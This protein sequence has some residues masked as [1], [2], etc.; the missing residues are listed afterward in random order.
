MYMGLTLDQTA[1]PILRAGGGAALTGAA[2]LLGAET[3][4]LAF[5]A[6]DD[7]MEIRDTVTPANNYVGSTITKFGSVRASAALNIGSTGL[8]EW[9]PENYALRS[10]EFDNAA[11]W[12]SAFTVAANQTTAPDGTTTMDKFTVPVTTGPVSIFNTMNSLPTG[13][14]TFSIYLRPLVTARYITL[15]STDT[16][17][18]GAATI[19]LQTG[20]I[21]QTSGTTYTSSTA[22]PAT[23]GGYRLSVTVSAVGAGNH[24]LFLSYSHTAT[25]TPDA[26][27][28]NASAVGTGTE[29]FYAWGAS[30]NRGASAGAYLSTTTSIA[31]GL[32]RDYDARVAGPKYPIE[33]A[34][35]NRLIRSQELGFGGVWTPFS[36]TITNDDAVAPDGTTTAEKMLIGGAN[37]THQMYQQ[38][39]TTANTD[40]ANS[41]FAK[42]TSGQ[43]RYC[44]LIF[45]GSGGTQWASATFD[46]QTQT[47]SQTNAG[48]AG[49]HVASG[50]IPLANGWM[51][52]WMVGKHTDTTLYWKFTL[53]SSGTPTQGASGDETFSGP[54]TAYLHIWG[55]DCQ[56]GKY[57][58]SHI[59]T[60]GATVTRAAD[61]PA[62]LTS[63]FNYQAATETI[64][65]KSV[66]PHLL[67]NPG[68]DYRPMISIVGTGGAGIFANVASVYAE[69]G[70]TAAWTIGSQVVVLVDGKYAMGIAANNANLAINGVI[71]TLD[72]SVTVPSA[73][74]KI[75]IGYDDFVRSWGAW[76]NDG[77][78]LPRRMSDAELVTRTT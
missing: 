7:S 33:E 26:Q 27:G 72:T 60:A 69:I 15:A 22:T 65:V 46:L 16:T 47:V 50:V 25:F 24:Y 45:G 23:G 44:S 34:R 78:Q 41:I 71:Q 9:G 61:I 77:M 4:G 11:T 55:A 12:N 36:V 39:V 32:R 13:P 35:T 19:D 66:T 2:T 64:Y 31:Y 37:S 57:V 70:A 17:N 6:S 67:G 14:W 74:T 28:R 54:G 29:T 58:G 68:S 3:N 62:V 52:L 8:V 76:I 42:Y 63:A 10:Q 5:S 48:A 21:T 53:N 1:V 56:Y 30:I 38:T 18:H 51:R 73:V 59:P 49:T 40:N 75:Y 43:Q 20:T